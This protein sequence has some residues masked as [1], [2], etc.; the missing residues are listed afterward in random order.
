MDKKL[1]ITG[2]SV[3]KALGHATNVFIKGMGMLF[4]QVQR[5]AEV[6]LETVT[7]RPRPQTVADQ[8]ADVVLNER[9]AEIR[10]DGGQVAVFENGQLQKVRPG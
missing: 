1:E 5:G 4:T 9:T 3:G 10:I 6:Y 7:K 2:E 8:L